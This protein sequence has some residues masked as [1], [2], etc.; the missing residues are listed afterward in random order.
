MTGVLVLLVLLLAWRC[1]RLEG[2]M[3]TAGSLSH[4]CEMVED[5]SGIRSDTAALAFDLA[6]LTA[7][8]EAAS[9]TL[10]GSFVNRVVQRDYQHA[11]ASCLTQFRRITTN[12]LGNDP[13]AW[14]Q[15]YAK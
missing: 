11:V 10:T 3:F 2:Q 5:N 13:R 15:K 7:E 14:I 9:N 4:D 6:R 12:D 8:Y 1:F